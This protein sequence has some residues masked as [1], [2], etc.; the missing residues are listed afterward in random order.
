[1]NFTRLFVYF[2]AILLV[3]FAAGVLPTAAAAASVCDY[4]LDVSVTNHSARPIGFAPTFFDAGTGDDRLVGADVIVAPAQTGAGTLEGSFAENSV[5]GGFYYWFN[6]SVSVSDYPIIDVDFTYNIDVSGCGG[7]DNRLN[8]N[9]PAALV[10]IYASPSADNAYDIYTIDAATG[11][12]AFAD[13]VNLSDISAA[14]DACTA[15]SANALVAE[16]TG[17]SLWV[18]QPCEQLALTGLYRHGKPYT[19][20]FDIQ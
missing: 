15:S 8:V 9:D 17:F 16:G 4:R 5:I 20:L 18:I 13:R 7:P 6:D 2:W 1:M 10:A 12:G 19:F 14:Q 11:Q 3:L